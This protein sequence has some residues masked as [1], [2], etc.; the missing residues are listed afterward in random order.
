[1]KQLR[2]QFPTEDAFK[3][4]LTAQRMTVGQLREKR[5]PRSSC[6]SSPAARS[7]ADR[8]E[9]DRDHAFYEKNPDKFQ[10]PE[11]VRASHV[12]IMVPRARP[13]P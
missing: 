7:P 11:A 5:G 1:M 2:Q 10:Q 3:Q 8:G 12:L 9:A 13:P 4:A 6:R